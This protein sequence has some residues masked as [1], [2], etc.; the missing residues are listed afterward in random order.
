MESALQVPLIL[1]MDPFSYSDE[2]QTI[3]DDLDG[4]HGMKKEVLEHL[5]SIGME[6]FPT[7]R[8]PFDALA[9]DDGELLITSVGVG[10]EG[11]RKR[12]RDLNRVSRITGGD[13][14]I[15]VSE[16]VEARRI[17]GTPV[18]KVSELKSTDDAKHL[19]RLIRDRI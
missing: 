7:Q 13:S 4:F 1:P 3:R 11:I 14:M 8:C 9:R 2:L 10:S 5:D 6:V 18:I 12:A 19:I 16:S 15:V 17:D